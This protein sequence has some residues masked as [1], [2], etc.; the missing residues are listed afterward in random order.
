[1]CLLKGGGAFQRKHRKPSKVAGVTVEAN[2]VPVAEERNGRRMRRKEG[3]R[4]EKE[5]HVDTRREITEE[6]E[7]HVKTGGVDNN[8]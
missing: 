5:G 8:I 6:G 3:R 1:M 4:W 7:A 2:M